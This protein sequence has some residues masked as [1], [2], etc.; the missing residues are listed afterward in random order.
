MDQHRYEGM[1]AQ[2]EAQAA[3]A[4][5][6]FRAK[7][8]LFSAAAYLS[9]FGALLALAGLLYLGVTWALDKHRVVGLIQISLFALVLLP[10]F[11]AVARMFFMR[12]GPPEGRSLTRA[13]APRL[14]EVLD[15]MRRKLKGP[16]I[17]QV[18]INREYNAAIA[19]LPRWGLFGR[20]TNYLML[21]LPYLLGAPPREML[22]TVAHEYGHL[23][24][25]HGKLGAWVYR[26]RRTFGALYEQLQRHAGNSM[27]HGMMMASLNTF[28]PRY[29]AYTFVMSRQ[30]EYE[31]DQTATDL[32]TA[33]INAR[34]LI[35]DA[36]LGR[37]VHETFWPRLWQ[38]ADVWARP[39]FMPFSAMRTAFQAS[40]DEWATR[41]RLAEAWRRD[42]DCH[43][44][45]PALRERVEATGQRCAL[46]GRIEHTAAD[47]LLGMTAK[48][49]IDEFDQAWW[50]EV[51]KEWETRNQYATRSKARLKELTARP[52]TELPLHALQELALL[53]AEFETPA[54]AKPI[55]E[56]LMRQPGG[57]FP[58]PAYLY[59]NILL[60]EG[61]DAGLDHLLSAARGDTSL[62]EQAAQR[63]YLHLFEKRGEAAAQAWWEKLSPDDA[64]E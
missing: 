15:K 45:H 39:S 43:D 41:E 27:I 11:Y 48:R 5:A 25:A 59:G 14:F 63:G 38:L 7:V 13:E 42:S 16:P 36:L 29:N 9:L 62:H 44:T 31:A 64:D 26:Q 53:T 49:L 10:L 56:H 21:G 19:Q 61:D 60:D 46:P 54:A 47:A 55:L 6:A 8:L 17:H 30:N 32:I 50:K 24:G 35:R 3:H 4:P 20:P 23:C 1:I 22:A 18:L 51:K 58:K 28:M 12:I 37:W 40:Y 2:L 52:Q 57:P 34:G 33:E